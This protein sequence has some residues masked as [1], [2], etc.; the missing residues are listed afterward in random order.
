MVSGAAYAARQASK[1]EKVE[2]Y[3]RKIEMELVAI[4]PF[5][6]SLAEDK[7]SSIK[8]EISRKIFG[9]ADAMEISNKDEPYT[10]M[11]KMVQKDDLLIQLLTQLLNKFPK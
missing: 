11:D 1:Q 2:R 7:Q 9:N 4:D 3:A 8:E 6:S 5:I 10:A